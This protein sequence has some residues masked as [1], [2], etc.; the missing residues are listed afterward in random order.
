[1]PNDE[2]R[3]GGA[4][5]DIH[6]Q[7]PLSVGNTLKSGLVFGRR[8]HAENSAELRAGHRRRHADP[9]NC[10]GAGRLG[11]CGREVARPQTRRDRHRLST[12]GSS[13]LP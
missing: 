2:F 7:A 6:D 13:A 1:M 12:A 5:A 8:Q 4:A 11:Q 10:L 9:R 3:R